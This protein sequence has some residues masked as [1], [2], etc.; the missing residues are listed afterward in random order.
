VDDDVF[1]LEHGAR[2]GVQVYYPISE[3][4]AG[5]AP[6]GARGFASFAEIIPWIQG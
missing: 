6:N 2:Y 1:N 5:L 4:H 3:R